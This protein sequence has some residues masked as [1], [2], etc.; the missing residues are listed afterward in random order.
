MSGQRERLERFFDDWDGWSLLLMAGGSLLCLVVLIPALNIGLGNE[1]SRFIVLMLALTAISAGCIQLALPRKVDDGNYEEIIP[2]P[3]GTNIEDLRELDTQI[4]LYGS[5]QATFIRRVR[6]RRG[7]GEAELAALDMDAL[8]RLV[9][10]P[11]LA[12]LVAGR[13][14][15]S[16]DDFGV[17]FNRLLGKVEDWK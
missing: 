12:G 8:E 15:P 10:D 16:G 4:D 17:T 14:R 6:V 2:G 11:E 1:Q 3:V 9:G 5:L 7:M 13:M